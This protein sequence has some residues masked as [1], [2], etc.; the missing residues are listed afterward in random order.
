MKRLLFAAAA[1]LLFA[2]LARSQP[3]QV[4]A[5][6]LIATEK[7]TLAGTSVTSIS[8]DAALSGA[9]NTQL[10]TALAVKTYADALDATDGDKSSTN[11]NQTVS[12]GTGIS[13]VQTGQN[14][15]V[16]NTGDTNA[17]D[18]LTI[19]S[20]AGG[21]LTG[22]F[23]NLQIAANAVGTAEIANGSVASADMTSTV[24]PGSCTNCNVTFDAAGRATTFSNGSGGGGGTTFY[25]YST[26]A[27][28]WVRATGT[29]VTLSKTTSG[30]QTWTFSIPS[31]VRIEGW[32]ILSPSPP[33]TQIVFLTF[34]YTGNT[35]TNQ[36][37]TTANVPI[38]SGIRMGTA[39]PPATPYQVVSTGSGSSAVLGLQVS[40]VGNGDLT[41]RFTNWT[42]AL[43]SS[44]A[45]MI[46]GVF[47][48]L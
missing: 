16:T 24:T 12:A 35:T 17:A 19:S 2:S 9:A 26:G 32:R 33:T 25:E 11:E 31:G 47:P 5:K 15:T 45:S 7:L 10:P 18:D 14:F 34:D 6:N 39:T 1:L 44:G 30:D 23:S 43:V 8:T 22:T 48:T 37:Y 3:A 13:V 38:V 20:T 29:G 41:L 28:G 46:Q 36:D 4:K 40:A 27:D 42:T 21:D